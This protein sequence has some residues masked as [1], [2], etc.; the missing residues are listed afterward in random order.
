[1]R[2]RSFVQQGRHGRRPWRFASAIALSLA[3]T[4][5]IPAVPAAF[6]SA[7]SA[8][9]TGRVVGLHGVQSGVSVWAKSAKGVTAST[10]TNSHGTFVLDNLRPSTYALKFSDPRG[11]IRYS[12]APTNAHYRTEWLGGNTSFRSSDTITLKAGEKHSGVRE[13]IGVASSISGHVYVNGRPAKSSDNVAL[14]AFDADKPITGKF[15]GGTYHLY[16]NAGNYRLRV[17]STVG[18]FATFY[19]IDPADGNRVFHMN[20]S[21]IH[22]TI[23]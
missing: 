16:F 22:I 15:V 14:E 1:M 23:P 5:A 17:R 9:I 7:D 4:V 21:N 6:A 8:A 13:V 12:E 2:L 11:L 18:A 19:V 20:G 3:A 10:I